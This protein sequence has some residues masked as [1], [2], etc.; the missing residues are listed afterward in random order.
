MLGQAKESRWSWSSALVGAVSAAAAAAI[1]AGKPRDPSFQLLS[2]SLTSFKLHLPVLD[3]ELTLTVHV[4][5]PNIV[6]IHYASSTMSIFYDGSLLGTAQLEAASQPA[7]SCS[8]I[9]LAARLDGIQLAHHAAKFVS[10]LANREMVLDAAVDIEGRAK[11]VWWEHK[12]RAHVSSHV[13]VDPVF[14]DV[15]D[16]EN[17]SEVELLVP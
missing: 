17:R 11:V 2:I 7:K 14:L 4:T 1:L 5:N 12:F 3:V 13:V 10:D 15:I 9:R 8:I 6:P 16:Q